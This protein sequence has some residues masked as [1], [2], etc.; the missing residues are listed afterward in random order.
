MFGLGVKKALRGLEQVGVE[1][2]GQAAIAG[3]DDEDDV[4]FLARLQQRM[5]GLAGLRIDD[6]GALQP[7]T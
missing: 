4:V 6:V 3:D 2:S 7:A 1:A 5:L